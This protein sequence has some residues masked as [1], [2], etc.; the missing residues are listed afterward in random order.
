MTTVTLTDR[1]E[2][3]QRT[4]LE[5]ERE[6]EPFTYP[7]YLEYRLLLFGAG[8]SV[9]REG[10]STSMKEPVSWRTIHTRNRGKAID[11]LAEQNLITLKPDNFSYLQLDSLQRFE[12]F[13]KQYDKRSTLENQVFTQLSG[14]FGMAAGLLGYAFNHFKP[15]DGDGLHALGYTLT[16]GVIGL[17]LGLAIDAYRQYQAKEKFVDAFGGQMRFGKKNAL[18]AALSS[19]SEQ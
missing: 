18:E 4:V 13:S 3:F 8:Y 19:R 15:Q 9:F 16:G 7:D 14:I 11:V 5:E 10:N 12:D 6:Y 1:I 2:I 17:G